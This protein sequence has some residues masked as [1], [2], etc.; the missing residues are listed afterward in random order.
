MGSRLT[1]PSRNR[2]LA[3]LMILAATG[4]I[5][6]ASAPADAA[7]APVVGLDVGRVT[8]GIDTDLRA[9]VDHQLVAGKDLLVRAQLYGPGAPKVGGMR[10]LITRFTFPKPSSAP[11][12]STPAVWSRSGAPRLNPS[13]TGRF[14]GSP[15]FS[16]WVPGSATRA[17]GSYTIEMVGRPE[18]ALKD[19]GAHI[20]TAF[21][22]EA[23]DIRILLYPWSFPKGDPQYRAYD[24]ASLAGIARA[25][26]D[27]QRIWPARAGAG[28]LRYGRAKP[29]TTVSPGVRYYVAPAFQCPTASS[30]FA[31]CDWLTRLNA[32]ALR[33][34]LNGGDVTSDRLDWAYAIAQTPSSGGGSSCW[35]PRTLGGAQDLNPPETSYTANILVQELAHCMGAVAPTS[36]NSQPGDITHALTSLIPYGLQPAAVNLLTRNDV[37]RP[38]SVMFGTVALDR[39]AFF[40]GQEW[41]QILKQTAA[42]SLGSKPTA[43]SAARGGAAPIVRTRFIWMGGIDRSDRVRYQYSVIR[44]AAQPPDLQN[45]G[46]GSA[47]AMI[48]RDAAGTEVGRQPFGVNFEQPHQHPRVLPIFLDVPLPAAA[49]RFALAR[50]DRE[51][52]VGRLDGGR[53]RVFG[54][55]LHR[56]RTGI[57]VSWRASDRDSRALR[58]AVRYVPRGGLA[59]LLASGLTSRSFEL[60]TQFAAAAR[61]ARLVVEASDGAQSARASSGSFSVARTAPATTIVS[62]GTRTRLRSPVMLLGASYDSTD[63]PLE[64]RFLEWRIDGRP[65]GRGQRLLVRLDRGKHT[66]E[67]RARG[68]SGPATVVRQLIRVR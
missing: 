6:R 29:G 24:K 32:S 55:R 22:A 8:Q 16:C 30:V 11:S 28:P 54:L 51:L 45:D 18:G 23:T 9:K 13:A 14:D 4:L 43:G 1:S 50:N 44:P 12:F 52:Y 27:F 42:T 5:A 17:P 58:Y 3:A 67:L 46:R 2:A 7:P 47:Y 38:T 62:P 41:N 64:G 25:M 40:E 63:G 48:F 26:L 66:L 34:D 10:C 61:H 53:P 59:V 68:R 15:T 19:E 37:P 33:D 57:R 65:R 39:T 36:P 49:T 20:R 60:P 31:G 56:T 21:F 35:T